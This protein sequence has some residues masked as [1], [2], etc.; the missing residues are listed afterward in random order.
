MDRLQHGPTTLVE[1]RPTGLT[2]TSLY[3]YMT[4]S[5]PLTSPIMSPQSSAPVSPG[6]QMADDSLTDDDFNMSDDHS[7]DESD[8]ESV[9]VPDDMDLDDVIPALTTK[10]Q[11]P[12]SNEVVFNSGLMTRSRAAK[13]AASADGTPPALQQFYHLQ[14]PAHS[15]DPSPPFPPPSGP[16]DPINR[17]KPEAHGNPPV[18]ANLRA[19]LNN[20]VPY[21]QSH[22]GSIY[23][24]NLMAQGVLLDAFTGT[25][26][27]LGNQVI[28]TS[29]AGGRVRDE[30]T[31]NMIRVASQGTNNQGY[32]ALS[33][34]F[35]ARRPVVLI[36]GAGNPLLQVRVEHYYNVLDY[37]HIT[38]IWSEGSINAAG[39]LIQHYM[40]RFERVDLATRSWWE[41][42][43]ADLNPR[44]QPGEYHCRVQ[45]CDNCHFDN[46]E[47]YDQ[48]WTCLE[49]DC[50]R[51]FQFPFEV[52][53]DALQ[54][55]QA[56]LRRRFRFTNFPLP[57]PLVPELPSALSVRP[58]GMFGTEKH[59]KRG[60]VCP[61]CF[62]CS[63]RVL[64]HE[65]RCENPSGCEYVLHIPIREVPMNHIMAET[66]ASILRRRQKFI[67]TDND[68]LA[69]TTFGQGYDMAT[70]YLPGETDARGEHDYVGS[71]T[72]FRP[73][74]TT[75]E[76]PGG[77]NDLF[78][79]MQD[80]V[81]ERKINLR[82]NP[83]RNKGHR[84]EELTSHFTSNIGAD[85]KFGVVVA[86]SSGFDEAPVPVMQALNRLT[87][88]GETATK[89]TTRDVSR[90]GINADKASMPDEFREFNEQLI[91]GYFEE[92]KI[93]YHDDGE[94][95]LGPTVATLS[96]GSPSVM[97]FR[98]KKNKRIGP[99]S[100]MHKKNRPPM[101]SFVL[102]HG[103]MVAMHG[104]DIHKHY[105]HK[106]DP[107]GIMRYALTCRYIRPE[108]MADETRRQLA[109]TKGA[110]PE[111]W[112]NRPYLGEDNLDLLASPAAS[113]HAD[114]DLVMEGA[115]N[116]IMVAPA[117]NGLAADAV[118]NDAVIED[119]I[120]A[121][122][123]ADNAVVADIITTAQDNEMTNEVSI[124]MSV[125]DRFLG[126]ITELNDIWR[127]NPGL[128]S[129]LSQQ[130]RETVLALAATLSSTAG[131]GTNST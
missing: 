44:H 22:Q 16:D 59:F 76:R 123:T 78:M 82:R 131:E 5:S 103:D 33:N 42:A 35:H 46:D 105:E 80:A 67:H 17:S 4:T 70:F 89:M 130:D 68:V 93:S 36:V 51:F 58:G 61:L 9:D 119:A 79:S 83:A 113:G 14:S 106:V 27:Y 104:T 117:A 109:L 91:L 57:Q 116:N 95:E 71:I 29:V 65:W 11:L 54:Y 110:V 107:E 1:K 43:G 13:L 121:G 120:A 74:K 52:D 55:S 100:T 87:W 118:A 97:C 23:S 56:F 81:R 94:K 50:E 15:Q 86:T 63:R 115:A 30:A 62:Y 25:R 45:R 19:A 49:P 77:L 21:H 127:S 48:G 126:G 2:Q 60:I 6:T 20:A 72:I 34:A 69:F 125:E 10:K 92:S 64:W 129:Q 38:N 31:G 40:V 18:T 96:L 102:E 73:T 32:K 108:M 124:P 7:D 3:D 84:I 128:V 122:A 66:A 99:Q 114:G 75:L 47:I 101:V 85:Y 39:E 24:S 53:L 8:D 12:L 111:F 98:P 112:K 88:A 41:T 37:F 28:I 90:H 26:D